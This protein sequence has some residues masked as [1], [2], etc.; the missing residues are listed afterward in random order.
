MESFTKFEHSNMDLVVHVDLWS[1][2]HVELIFLK[3]MYIII[4]LSNVKFVMFPLFLFSS[5]QPWHLQV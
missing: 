2:V 1:D 3:L 5:L 4:F